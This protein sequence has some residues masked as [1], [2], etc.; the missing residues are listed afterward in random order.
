MASNELTSVRDRTGDTGASCCC[1]APGG[2]GTTQRTEPTT[3][4]PHGDDTI[5]TAVRGH[6]ARIALA[7]APCCGG[8]S[9]QTGYDAGEL[10]GLPDEAIMGLGCGNPVA[11]ADIAEGETVL[12][13][14]SGGGIDV[15][16][17]ARRT[18]PSGRVIG[19]DMTPEMLERA[20]ENAARAGIDHAEF[21]LGVIEDLPVE[22]ATVD[23]ILSNCVINL[24]P[25]KAAV[26]AEAYRVLRPGGRI[27]V[28]D[29][30]RS[31]PAPEAIDPE[32][33]S[34]CVDGALLLDDY[35]AAIGSAGFERVEVLRREGE[36]PLFSATV[37]AWKA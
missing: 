28:S 25:D 11:L 17:A 1:G 29:I 2:T 5:R 21:R 6:Y 31:V 36:G 35:L 3:E 37:R 16:L 20:E 12:D 14:G 22:S 8:G 7:D 15:F 33:W 9:A 23:L 26:F 13:L 30:V 4:A 18:G 34:S 19:V 27:V 24:S 10:A 32:R